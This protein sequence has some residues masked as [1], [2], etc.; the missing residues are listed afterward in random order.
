MRILHGNSETQQQQHQQQHS[1]HVVLFRASPKNF[2][3]TFSRSLILM[4][5]WWKNMQMLGDGAPGK[6]SAHEEKEWREV[7][8]HGHIS[9]NVEF[10]EG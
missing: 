2:K 8:Y 10:P 6:E 7:L 5:P 1:F 4:G 3:Q 9:L